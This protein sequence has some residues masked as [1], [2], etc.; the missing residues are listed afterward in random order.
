MSDLVSSDLTGEDVLYFLTN[1][2][3]LPEIAKGLN[4]TGAKVLNRDF[5]AR[6]YRK[7]KVLSAS[8]LLGIRTPQRW[9]LSQ[10]DQGGQ[11]K[12]PLYLKSEKHGK[13]LRCASKD[14]LA[15]ELDKL[16]WE[17]GWYLEEAIDGAG[18]VTEKM[19]LIDGSIYRPYEDK[20]EGDI[21]RYGELT[22]LAEALGLDL[23]SI[24]IIIGD[25]GYLVIDIN[26]CPA[27]FNSGLARESLVDLILRIT[28]E[29][30]PR[31]VVKL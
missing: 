7:S 3:L 11:P 30:S 22:V 25:S 16:D 15:T 19:Y 13:A 10:F 31:Y 20:R 29:H 24:D 28:S 6:H 5:L 12:F 14:E 1:D 18:F 4:S 8:V 26:H 2:P 17:T 21:E 23:A 9:M 27:L